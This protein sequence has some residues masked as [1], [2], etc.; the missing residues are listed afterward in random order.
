MRLFE[1]DPH[2]QIQTYTEAVKTVHAEKAVGKPHTLWCAFAHFYEK[3]GDLDNAR[4]VF[5]KGTQVRCRHPTGHARL[6]WAA[7]Q[8]LRRASQVAP[9]THAQLHFYTGST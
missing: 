2:Q 5:R 4:A 9:A 6:P 8:L 1:K 3:H 7:P